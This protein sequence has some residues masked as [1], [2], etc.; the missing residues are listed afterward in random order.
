MGVILRTVER[1]AS[2]ADL[3]GGCYMPPL[4]AVIDDT[5]IDKLGEDVCF[6]VASQNIPRISLDPVNTLGRLHDSSLKDTNRGSEALEQAS[7]GLQAIDK[8]GLRGKFKVCCLQ[9]ML[10]PKFLWPLLVNEINL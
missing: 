8:C 5:M 7:V 6:K 2:P 1:S 3:G 9:F 10:I 4:K